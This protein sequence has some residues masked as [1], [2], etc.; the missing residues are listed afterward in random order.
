[1]KNDESCLKEL[2]EMKNFILFVKNKVLEFNID[3]ECKETIT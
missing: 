2:E 1:L 3:E